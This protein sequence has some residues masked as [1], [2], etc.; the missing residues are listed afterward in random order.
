MIPY[1]TERVKQARTQEELRAEYNGLVE[2][3]LTPWRPRTRSAN[4]ERY[5]EFRTGELENL[6]KKRSKLYRRAIE[7]SLQE[8]WHVYREIDRRIKRIPRKTLRHCYRK[9]LL[10][11]AATSPDAASQKVRAIMDARKGNVR[12]NA[13][14]SPE[15]EPRQ[16]TQHMK[17]TA[18][19]A[20]QH[21]SISQRLFTV[22]PGIETDMARA[23]RTAKAVKATGPDEVFSEE[24]KIREDLATEIV[25]TLWKKC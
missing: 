19:A 14:E 13:L 23:I 25:M 16:F 9:L 20:H 8:H 11:L 6:S 5:R 3:L 12:R 10:G 7:T 21:A 22:P 24:L 17:E 1:W 15:V 4:P 2:A 18:D